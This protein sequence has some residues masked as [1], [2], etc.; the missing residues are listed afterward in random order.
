MENKETTT[1]AIY[2]EDHKTLTNMCK[3]G[4]NY[5]EVLH[6]LLLTKKPYSIPLNPL[7]LKSEETTQ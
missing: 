5:R 7:E 3:K 6:K 4:E 1:I 2:I